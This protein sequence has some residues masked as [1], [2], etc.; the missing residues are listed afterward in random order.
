MLSDDPLWYKDAIIYQV[1]VKAF[2]DS[3]DD[4]IGDLRGFVE[5][6]DYVQDLGV[7]ALWFLPFYPSPLR[8]AGYDIAD[9][10]SIN[11]TYGTMRD[12]SSEERR[13]GKEC[14][15]TCRSRSSPYHTKK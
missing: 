10:R 15:C 4:G 3:N 5:K 6:L 11:P 12:F 14:V 8:D 9:Y 7:T 13:V 2:F 1:H